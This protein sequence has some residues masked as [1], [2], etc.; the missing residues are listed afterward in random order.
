[1]NRGGGGIQQKIAAH[2]KVETVKLLKRLGS[3]DARSR[4]EAGDHEAPYLIDGHRR[5]SQ[6]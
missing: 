3:A 4:E 6:D 1:M 5:V 2:Y